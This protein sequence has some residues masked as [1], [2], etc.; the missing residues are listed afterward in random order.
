MEFLKRL[1][2]GEKQEL[3]DLREYHKNN[4]VHFELSY[5]QDKLITDQEAYIIKMK[6]RTTL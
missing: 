3:N 6:L 1:F 2:E 4:N 5:I